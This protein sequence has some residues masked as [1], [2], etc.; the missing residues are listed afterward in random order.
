MGNGWR[1]ISHMLLEISLRRGVSSNHCSGGEGRG[2]DDTRDC[3]V[4][5]CPPDDEH[6][7]SKL[8]E[9][10]NKLII[11]F[12][13]SSWLILRN[14]KL[15]VYYTYNRTQL[16]FTQQY[17]RYTYCIYGWDIVVFDCMCNTQKFLFLTQQ[18]V[19]SGNDSI[20][21]QLDGFSWNLNFYVFF[22]FFSKICRK[23]SSFVYVWHE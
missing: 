1:V 17:S 15:F 14:K 22:F 9:A 18:H 16:Y 21:P 12:S 2:C 11:K 10:W 8:V 20:S 3:I 6:L 13:A 5:F 19:W 4:Q 23:H 7:C